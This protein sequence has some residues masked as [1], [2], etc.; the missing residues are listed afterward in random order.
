MNSKTVNRIFAE[1]ERE[2]FIGRDAEFRRILNHSRRTGRSNGHMLLSAPLAGSSELLRQVYDYAFSSQAEQ[3]PIYF[4]VKASDADAAQ[5]ARRFL[6][7]F[8]IQIVAFNRKDASII[9]A[10]PQPAELLGLSLPADEAWIGRL[11]GMLIDD[12]ETLENASLRSCLSAPL[13]ASNEGTNVFV[14]IDD[15]HLLTSIKNG[16]VFLEYLKEA[17]GRGDF[18][19]VLSGRRRFPFG[20]LQY[21]STLI[22]NL[23]FAAAGGL[24]QNLAKRF[25]VDTS[26]EVR[27]LIAAQLGGNPGLMGFLFADAREKLAEFENFRKAEATYAESVFGGRICKYYDS[28]FDS[29]APDPDTQTHLLNVFS[30]LRKSGTR[31]AYA[32]FWRANSGLSWHQFRPALKM[33]NINEIVSVGSNWIEPTGNNAAL[34][35]YL[36]G[37]LRLEIGGEAR[38]K[39]LGEELTR[40]VVRAPRLM[41]RLYRR[42]NAVG[43]RE[44]MQSFDGQE[45]PAALID[46]E[47]FKEKYKGAGDQEIIRSMARDEKKISLPIIVYVAHTAA[48]YHQIGELVDAELSAVALGFAKT[49]NDDEEVVWLA[50]E[51]DSKLEATKDLAE[52]WCDRLE[53]VAANCGFQKFK[54]WLVAN[55]GFSSGALADLN[56]RNAYGSS[57]KQAALLKS[58]LS[59]TGQDKDNPAVNT[60]EMVVPMGDE[61]ELLA[62]KTV[63]EIARRHNFPAKAINQ[64]KTAL[65]EAYI[66][67]AEHSH[68]PDRKIYQK[69]GVDD[70]KISITIENRG[71]R[72]NAAAAGGGNGEARRGWGI[73]LIKGLMDEV[74]SAETDD[75]SSLTMVKYLRA[76]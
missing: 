74:T 34:D 16:A 5:A 56:N 40:F 54:I 71:V 24:V 22:E 30:E 37:R 52:F 44:I 46:Y 53:M 25:G 43:L 75:G 32:N 41:A 73:K 19:F 21:E 68:S 62:A 70:D 18:P 64:I 66:N 67:A 4:A 65:V 36:T 59:E 38:A 10:S 2:S 29:V 33:L 45:M 57:R 6:S 26:E 15:L 39:V 27:D 51:V 11:A 48:F 17:F 20:T 28:V 47:L 9:A 76:G 42:Q 69:I 1:N 14:M 12:D 49:G 61:S 31:R 50:A 72:F 63:E 60:Y 23:P 55:E 7:D 8:L 58:F 3:I 35:D 13:R